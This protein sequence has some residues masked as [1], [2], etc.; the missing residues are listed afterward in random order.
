MC[1]AITLARCEC[2]LVERYADDNLF[3]IDAALNDV[4]LSLRIIYATSFAAEASFAVL[5]TTMYF[6]SLAQDSTGTFK[7]Y[8]QKIIDFRGSVP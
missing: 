2:A 3:V 4:E 5:W 7:S 8:L 1:I 6:M